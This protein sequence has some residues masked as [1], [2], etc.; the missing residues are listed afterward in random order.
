ML[1]TV[2]KTELVQR[3]RSPFAHTKLY[4]VQG[5]IAPNSYYHSA[6]LHSAQCYVPEY[7]M[8]KAR[9]PSLVHS[10][11]K[12]KSAKCKLCRP[13]PTWSR[14]VAPTSAAPGLGVELVQLLSSAVQSALCI[15][16]AWTGGLQLLN[17]A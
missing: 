5:T 14:L 13:V 3:I 9:C 12:T 2:E 17:S 1:F 7:K 6:G 10:A 11:F 4:K 15:M 8:W 16:L